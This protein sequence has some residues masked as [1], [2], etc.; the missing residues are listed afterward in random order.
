MSEITI[1]RP[2]TNSNI[3]ERQ[4]QVVF[5]NV[6]DQYVK[7]EDLTVHFTILNDEKIDLTEDSIGL[8][9]AGCTN[10]QECLAYAPIQMKS[11]INSVET[12]C[13]GTAVFS[14]SL[15]PTSDDEFYQFCY[16]RN[17]RKYFGSSIPFQLNCSIDD[18]DLLTSTIGEKSSMKSTND[19]LIAL[20]DYDN[21]DLVVIH[22]KSMLVEEK[23]R[24]ENR[25]L[26]DMNRRL[27]Q[28]K[29]E[30]KAKVEL[31]N[32]KTNE[33]MNKFQADM[34][35]LA[36]THR[37]TIDEL[38]T[39]QQVEAKLRAEYDACGVLCEQYKTESLQFAK[40]CS[41]LNETNQELTNDMTKLQLQMT[42]TTQLTNEQLTKI[43]D[44]EKRLLKSNELVKTANQY[45]TQ[46]EQQLCD[47]RLTSEKYQKSI[48]GQIDA[49]NKQAAQQEN[50]IHALESANSLLKEEF[51]SIKADNTFLLAMAK[52]DKQ[53]IKDLQQQIDVMN[54]EYQTQTQQKQTELEI[55]R[56]ELQQTQGNTNDFTLLKNS[57][58]EIEKRCVKHQKSE[59]EVKKQLTTYKE[60]IVEL[61]NKNQDLTE[62]LLAGADEYKTLYRKYAALERMITKVNLQSSSSSLPKSNPTTLS[63]ETGLNEEA[64]VTLLRNSYELQQQ[65]QQKPQ[66][67]EDIEEDNDDVDNEEQQEEEVEESKPLTSTNSNEEIR[68]CPMCYWEFPHHLTL[69]N[70]KDHIENH[71]A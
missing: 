27:E 64:L 30:L 9:R 14:S 51:Q 69:E 63:N 61:E 20:N 56:K 58:N 55:L 19:G 4:D 16:L 7:G 8:L 2:S 12:T 39:R 42:A 6:A 36:A 26:L 41:V 50:Q 47:L 40:R 34:Q 71:F 17:K 33:Y 10:I 52:E 23:L 25:H 67:E 68:E 5:E 38:T 11:S 53:L 29:D 60:L 59:I 70:K 21:D 1:H 62:R 57:F 24:Q 32:L 43:N 28:Q 66:V 37:A 15:L 48:Q 44:L 54:G 3:D 46:L 13:H 45:Q 31:C 49:Y 65:D 35:V 18:I 22:T